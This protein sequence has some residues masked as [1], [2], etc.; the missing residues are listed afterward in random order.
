MGGDAAGKR[1]EDGVSMMDAV[2]TEADK[3]ALYD[4]HLAC[5]PPDD[6]RTRFPSMTVR[7]MSAQTALR[8]RVNEPRQLDDLLEKVFSVGLVLTDVHRLPP[9]SGLATYEVRVAGELGEP[10]L[11]YLRW[12]HYTVPEQTLVRLTAA[13]ADLHGFLRAC[14]D[15]G[16]RIEQVRRV[17]AAPTAP[18]ES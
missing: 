8:Q 4:V 7:S 16:V 10:L 6:L 12:F 1:S 15:S 5:R 2:G 3:E 13:Q 11:R 14:T 18:A 17:Y 9:S